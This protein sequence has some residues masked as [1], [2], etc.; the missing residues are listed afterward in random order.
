MSSVTKSLKILVPREWRRAGR[1]AWNRLL[2]LGNVEL[3]SRESWQEFREMVAFLPEV[4]YYSCLSIGNL[5]SLYDFLKRIERERVPGDFVECGVYRGG[6]AAVLGHALRRSVSRRLWLFDSFEGLPAPTEKDGFD[7]GTS[8]GTLVGNE[9]DVRALL[10]KA[11]A[12]ADRVKIV[13]G[14]FQDT[15][16]RAEISSVALLHLDVD[17]YE[18][19]KL[20]LNYFYDLLSPGAVVVL[21]DYSWESPGY[22]AAVEEIVR[23]RSLRIDLHTE[24]GK[25]A[26]FRN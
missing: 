21:D 15:L 7:D 19:A 4:S 6:S 25:P 8:T 14:W 26:W 9:R 10:C 3:S 16:S 22:K 17:F 18:A 2:L 1:I 23:E 24:A 13:R 12:P 11:G 20:C 5:E